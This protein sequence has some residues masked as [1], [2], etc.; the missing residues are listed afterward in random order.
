[1]IFLTD[2]YQNKDSFKETK[3]AKTNSNSV[4]HKFL[5]LFL[6]QFISALLFCGIL[7]SANN[8]GDS[9][10]KDYTA[11]LGKALRNQVFSSQF[12]SE[13]IKKVQE[14]AVKLYQN[15]SESNFSESN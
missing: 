7:L 8:L 3:A 11:A 14:K 1:M 15:I 6:R 5:S 2:K 12:F 4:K 10:T 13:E 9:K